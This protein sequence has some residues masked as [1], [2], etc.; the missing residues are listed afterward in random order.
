MAW[1]LADLEGRGVPTLENV[2]RAYDLR[3]DWIEVK[4]DSMETGISDGEENDAEK[5]MTKGQKFRKWMSNWCD[6]FFNQP[7][8]WE[9]KVKSYPQLELG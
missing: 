2:M 3:G 8:Y 9:L 1:T 7:R 5:E 6:L 4:G